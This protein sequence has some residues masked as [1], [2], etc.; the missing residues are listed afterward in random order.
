M[1]FKAEWARFG[2][3]AQHS[4]FCAW[5]ER[6]LAPLPGLVV[7]QEVWGVDAHIE[8]LTLRF[9]KAGYVALAPDL[10]AEAGE[11]PASLS[12]PRLDEIKAFIDTTRPP[13]AWNDPAAREQALANV[14][15]PRRSEMKESFSTLVAS[16]LGHTEGFMPRLLDAAE[17]LRSERPMSRGA[18]VGAVGYCLGG[19]LAARL[20][21]ADPKL[22]AAVIFY[23]NAP[24]SG[25]IPNITCPVLGLYGGLDTRINAGLAEFS[26]AMAQHGKR[27]ESH[28]FEGAKHA[29]F[30]DTRPSYDAKAS[31]EA[32]ARTLEF[33]RREL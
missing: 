1:S 17:Y 19:G 28:V 7:I 26:S 27:F 30:N 31:R 6:A 5:P 29:F 20:A 22:S 3:D 10:F 24:P 15:E 8:D 2:K 25:Q 14:P 4:G 32:F 13:F 21:C 16:A 9:A 12:R 18:K 11:R 33:L 23:G